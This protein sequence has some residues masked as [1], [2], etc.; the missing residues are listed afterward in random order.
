[1]SFNS[2]T[3]Y[4]FIMRSFIFETKVKTQPLSYNNQNYDDKLEKTLAVF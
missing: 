3:K 2:K 4:E 1:M